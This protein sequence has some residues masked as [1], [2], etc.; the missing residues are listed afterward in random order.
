MS[1]FKQR[2]DFFKSL[3]IKNKLVAHEQAI[4]TKK[5]NAY[6]RMN[7]EE[8]LNAACVNWAHFPCVVHM[9]LAG[10]FTSEVAGVPKRKLFNS[11]LFLHRADSPTNMD[12]QEDA[13]DMAL[14]VMEQF[15][16]AIYNEY[17]VKG[18][19][20]AFNN[21]DLS[22]FSFHPVGPINANLFG[23]QLDFEDERFA[24][25]ITN[26]DSSKWLE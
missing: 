20:G 11:L 25:S 15:I 8:E 9:G 7:D 5:R 3:A 14:E 16:S 24:Q 6:F 21:L 23:W 26:Y 17:Q 13:Y 18:Y 10:R 4:G 1:F 2:S 19:C 12:S 22:R